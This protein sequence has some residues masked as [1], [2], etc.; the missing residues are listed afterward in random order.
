MLDHILNNKSVS[1]FYEAC[2]AQAQNL[3]NGTSFPSQVIPVEFALTD[4]KSIGKSQGNFF[5]SVRNTEMYY[6]VI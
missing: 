2:V 3:I 1:F 4:C 5:S 6:R